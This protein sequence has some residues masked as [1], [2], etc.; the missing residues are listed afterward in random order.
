LIS[1][2]LDIADSR[3]TAS[4]VLDLADRDVV[5]RRF[6]LD[7]DDLARLEDWVGAAGIRWG[8]DQEHRKPFHLDALPAGTWQSG[9]DRVLAGVTMSEDDQRLVANSTLPLDDVDSGSIVLAGQFAEFVDR[10]A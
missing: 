5:R 6:R 7:D 9:I 10:L 4:Q 3:L 8:L 1:Q 2:L